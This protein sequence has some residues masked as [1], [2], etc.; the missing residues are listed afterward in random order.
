MISGFSLSAMAVNTGE[1]LYSYTSMRIVSLAPS[2]TEILFEI[3]AGDLV[4]AT[5]SL[6]DFPSEA[7]RRESVGGWVNPD[8]DRVEEIDP[9]LVLASDSLQDGAVEQLEDRGLA[10][11]QLKPT[12]VDEVLESFRTVGEVAGRRGE[13][14]ALVSRF[15]EELSGI[16]LGSARIYCE[17]WTSPPMVSG[18][19]VP[20]LVEL[21]GG[22]YP[23]EEGERSREIQLEEL[24]RFEPELIVLNV[25]GAKEQFDA[26]EVN[27][28]DGWED[29][30][31]VRDGEIHVVDDA[32]LNRPG[33]R[34]V[35]GA[36]RISELVDNLN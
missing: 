36:R 33:P 15:R 22:E 30:P 11:K 10:V 2:N 20:G 29:L 18:N 32:L 26:E 35:E 23:V 3:G 6:C 21:C 12:T 19:W 14:E 31:A 25:C 28:R 34:L 5:T 9:D 4:V 16:D 7:V 24:S 27:I 17:E 1:V 8:L 13:A